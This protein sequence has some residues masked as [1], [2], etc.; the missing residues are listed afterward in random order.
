MLFSKEKES[1]EYYPYSPDSGVTIYV[2][3]GV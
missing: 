3:D 2:A 1:R